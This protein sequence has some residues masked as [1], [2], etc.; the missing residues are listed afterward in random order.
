MKARLVIVGMA[1]VLAGCIAPAP[2]SSTPAPT[3]GS[4]AAGTP[5]NSPGSTGSTPTPSPSAARTPVAGRA[6]LVLSGTAIGDF[7]LGA[8]EQS[9]LERDLVARLGKPKTGPTKVCQ[10]V[11]ERNRFAA[12][13]HSWSGL[14]VH[15]GRRDAA[16]IAV[17]WQVALDRVPDGVSLADRLPWRPTFADLAAGDGVEIAS[18]AGVKTAR[19]T[20]RALSYAGP[21]GASRPD[22]VNGGPEL[23]CR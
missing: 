2:V 11:G 19:L 23:A 7:P 12:F 3:T 15:Y 22:T 16:T 1:L 14:T 9:L 6:D 18:S 13:D 17:S 4:P 8:T 10:L 5:A 20:G 21:V